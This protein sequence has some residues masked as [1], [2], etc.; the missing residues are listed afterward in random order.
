MIIITNEV[1]EAAVII[2]YSLI[3]IISLIGNSLVVKIAFSGRWIPGRSQRA[4]TTT[5]V[6]IGSLSFSDLV[7]TIFNIPFNLARILLPYWPFGRALCY[8]VPFVQT[9]CVY[10][11]TFTMAAIALHRWRMVSHPTTV[12]LHKPNRSISSANPLRSFNSLRRTIAIVWLISFGLAAPTV[13]FNTLKLANVN[14][15]YVI[16]CRVDYPIIFGINASL[17]L[18]IEI[19][20]TQY[21]IPLLITGILYMK[22]ATVIHRQSLFNKITGSSMI[23]ND[24]N[25]K[26]QLSS[27]QKSV[28]N[29]HNHNNYNQKQQQ[30]S[31]NSAVTASEMISTQTIMIDSPPKTIITSS[32]LNLSMIDVDNDRQQ[33]HQQQQSAT[34]TNSTTQQSLSSS[35]MMMNPFVSSQQQQQQQSS[36]SPSIITRGCKRRR[37]LEVKRRRILMLSLVVA[38]FA[39]CWL[40]LNLYHLT[41]D[42]GFAQ[43]RLTV[44]LV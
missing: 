29:N 3:V 42:L 39:I 11:S 18:T 20:L 6:L 22:I 25:V 13:A 2:A 34:T 35:T 27:T 23:G 38:V 37:Q 36:S 40:P 15:H 5:D 9:A 28:M 31:Q 30:Q 44:F 21:L 4:R 1:N 16:R 26:T 17:L 41:I 33:Q 43:H 12:M 10:V 24:F 8:G 32:A 19:F 7:M 14:G